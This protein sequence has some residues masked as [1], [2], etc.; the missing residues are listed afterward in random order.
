MERGDK[1]LEHMTF[2]TNFGIEDLG[3]YQVYS[4][5]EIIA[6]LRNIGESNQLVR[7]IINGGTESVVT[8]ILKVDEANGLVIIDVAPS[9][10]QNQR[11]LQS[12]NISF[13][14]LLE[15]IRILFF[16][17]K[18]D[19]CLYE[20]L[21]AFSFAIPA[22]LIRLQRREFYR[23]LTPVTNPVR[24]TITIPHEVDESSTTVVVALQNVSGGGI[25]ILDDKKLLDPT[26]GRIYKD[27]RIDLPGGT[28]VV[29]TLQIRNSQE[30]TLPNGKAIRRLG[31]L[32]VD[33][34]KA[35]MNAVQ[36]YITRLER[37]QNAKTTGFN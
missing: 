23:V 11:I 28:L 1:K 4:R 5:R 37:E 33:L 18:V 22:S 17:T 14:T 24:C 9:Q 29:A 7:M 26:I 6:L 32:F 35:M 8:S 31:C 15:H 3:P 21:P 27:C 12:D 19:S 2:N 36:R 13:E 25:A 16:V 10:L 34:P 30:I 20:N